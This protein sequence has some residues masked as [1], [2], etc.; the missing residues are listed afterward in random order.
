MV[1]TRLVASWSGDVMDEDVVDERRS[2]LWARMMSAGVDWE[3]GIDMN[4][5]SS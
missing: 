2:D 5:C 4:V 3:G 1:R